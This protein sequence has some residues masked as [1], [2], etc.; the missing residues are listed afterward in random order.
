MMRAAIVVFTLL[1]LAAVPEAAAEKRVALVVGNGNYEH[2]G[3]LPN[4]PNDARLMAGTLRA[5]GFEVL[6]HVDVTQKQL[7]RALKAF[8]RRLEKAGQDSVALFF[9][10][11]H[12]VQVNG[13]N[14][15]LPVNA[16]IESEADV[17]IEAVA[18]DSALGIMAFAQS[19]LNFVILDACR[20]N[21]FSRG[22]RSGVRGLARMNAPRGTMVAYATAP[23]DVAADGDE[24]NSPYTA[25]LAREMMK[26]GVQVEEAF[27]NVRVAVMAATDDKQTP[28][29]S[30][31]LTGAFY[32]NTG[33]RGIAITPN[34]P[35]PAQS[36]ATSSGEVEFWRSVRDSGNAALYEAYLSRYPKGEFAVIARVKLDEL[37][38]RQSPVAAP[39]PAVP[40]QTASLT[41]PPKRK[42]TMVTA[43]RATRDLGIRRQPR[44]NSPVVESVP[45]DTVLALMDRVTANSRV[46]YRVQ[47]DAG[48]QGFVFGTFVE[49]IQ[50]PSGPAVPA[51]GVLQGAPPPQSTTI[52][53]VRVQEFRRGNELHLRITA[54]GKNNSAQTMV[55]K[56]QAQKAAM[57]KVR[58]A[59]M[60]RLSDSP[61]Y[62]D[63]SEILALYEK[64]EMVDLEYRD[65]GREVVLTYELVMSTYAQK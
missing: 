12:G 23:N 30:S 38:K 50:V 20:N 22:V 55:R 34:Q 42:P 19:R 32:F 61:Y 26:P 4:P 29:E 43:L 33:A 65:D 46:W 6:E 51:V 45:A 13:E 31:S 18:A 40:T 16:E 8:G 48:T 15:L 52:G 3:N 7:K 11:G 63:R 24:D 25:A 2:F 9:Y 10:A 14:Y 44:G 49:Q 47:T 62:L 37:K 59:L 5:L 56:I 1:L 17:N 58:G 36:A 35:P 28:W 57:K 64:G 54:S 53:G 27:R 39:A 41:P 60:T 21:P